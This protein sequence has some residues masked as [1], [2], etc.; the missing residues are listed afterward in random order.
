MGTLTDELAKLAGIDFFQIA[1][2][3][4]HPKTRIRFPALRHLQS[5]KTKKELAHM[6][7]VSLTPLRK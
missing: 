7:Q 5:S 4:S 3:E 1:K 2:R 6:F